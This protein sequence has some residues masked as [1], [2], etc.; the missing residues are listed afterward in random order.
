[1]DIPKAKPPVR[2]KSI[3]ELKKI[4]VTKNYKRPETSDLSALPSIITDGKPSQASVE[5]TDD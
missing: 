2:H 4:S 3:N 5:E 1:L